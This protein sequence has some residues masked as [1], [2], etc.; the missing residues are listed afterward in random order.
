VEPEAC[1][2]EEQFLNIA[3]R[4]NKILEGTTFVIPFKHYAKES[5]LK[6]VKATF[7]ESIMEGTE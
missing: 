2:T 7:E 4:H 6:L 1:S 5:K 3:S